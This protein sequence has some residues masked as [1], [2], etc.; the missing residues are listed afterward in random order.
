MYEYLFAFKDL[1]PWRISYLLCFHEER[2]IALSK[3]NSLKVY[4]EHSIWTCHFYIHVNDIFY[5]K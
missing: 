3:Q 2:I 5:G 4:I 1:T